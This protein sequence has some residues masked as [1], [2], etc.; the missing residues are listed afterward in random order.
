MQEYLDLGHPEAFPSEHMSMS[1]AEVFYLL[2]HAV[3]KSSSATTKVRAVLILSRSH[4]SGVSLNGLLLV[5][6]TV[7][8]TLISVLLW[9]RSHCSATTADVSKIYRA[10]QLAD[11]EISID[12]SGDLILKIPWATTK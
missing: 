9:F 7:Y 5:G 11:P 6:P 3:Y 12:L 1:L 2:M 10:V 8:P 4:S